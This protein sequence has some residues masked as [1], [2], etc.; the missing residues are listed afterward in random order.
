MIRKM[1]RTV[2]AILAAAMLAAMP[3]AVN[4]ADPAFHLS[5]DGSVTATGG[6]ATAENITFGQGP[7]GF[8]QAGVFDG[9][10]SRVV[11]APTAF[12]DGV[13]EF[14]FAAWINTTYDN[15]ASPGGVNTGIMKN[16]TW[17]P[18]GVHIGIWNNRFDTGIQGATGW[19]PDGEYRRTD[20]VNTGEW[21]HVASTVALSAAGDSV[22]QVLYVNGVQTRTSTAGWTAGALIQLTNDAGE[23]TVG[24]WDVAR[25]FNGSMAEVMLF[26][27]VLTAAEIAAVMNPAPPPPATPDPVAPAADVPATD[28]PATDAPATGAPVPTQQAP[29]R[30]PGTFDPITAA[31]IGA[32]VA[33]SAGA[34]VLKKRK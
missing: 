8:G 3:F 2:V 22:T 11:I 5:F 4:A 9:A 6:A 13:T 33:A 27:S 1:K 18:N 10:A 21:V 24:S 29:A 17:N 15:T 20:P 23:T 19:D 12:A 31:A 30:A 7:Q 26:D 28:A 34:V 32:I 16:P 14:T 25:W